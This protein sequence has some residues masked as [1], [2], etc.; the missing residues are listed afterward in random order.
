MSRDDEL[1]LRN[2]V[3]LAWE[4]RGTPSFREAV[5]AI[6]DWQDRRHIRAYERRQRSRDALLEVLRETNPDRRNQP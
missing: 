6:G 3:G 1:E 2:L 4:Q 5:A